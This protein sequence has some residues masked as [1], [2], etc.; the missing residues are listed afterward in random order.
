MTFYAHVYRFVVFIFQCFKSQFVEHF[1]V[2]CSS[3]GTLNGALCQSIFTHE[4]VMDKLNDRQ[5]LDRWEREKTERD[6]QKGKHTD[7]EI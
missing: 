7:R 4:Q 3:D 2:P 5:I 1:L 6:R